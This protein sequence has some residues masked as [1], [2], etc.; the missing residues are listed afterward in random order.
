[1]AGRGKKRNDRVANRMRRRHTTHSGR[2]ALRAELDEARHNF[3]TSGHG[4]VAA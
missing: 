2:Q 3:N 1:M 4:E